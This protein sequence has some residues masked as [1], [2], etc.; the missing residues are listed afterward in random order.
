MTTPPVTTPADTAPPVTAPVVPVATGTT[1]RVAADGS[2]RYRT[3]AEAAAAA[4]PGDTVL[5]APGSYAGLQIPVSGTKDAP[6]T[7]KADGG[8]VTLTSGGTGNG[9]L[10]L[11]GRS[12]VHVVG[13]G[14]S[15]SSRFGVYATNATGIVLQDCEVADSQDGGAVFIDSADIRILGC[16]VHGNN[17]KGTSADMEGVSL[18][19][20]DGFEIA[21]NHVHDNGEEGI[22]TKYETRNG[23]V[24]GN[25]VENNR[26]PNIYVD[27]AHAI[28]VFD[29]VSSGAKESSKAG[30]A[31]AVENY[32]KTRKTY[33]V[34]IYNNVLTGNAGGGISFWT[35]SSGTFSDI[36]IVNNTIVDNKKAGITISAGQFQG[37]NVLRNNIFSGN[38]QD[39][40]GSAA[41]FTADHNL[42]SG[43]SLGA[44]VV[45]GVLRFVNAAAGDLRLAPGSA[46]VDAGSAQGA[47]ATDITGAPRPS[48]AGFDLGA[49][50]LQVVPPAAAPADPPASAGALAPP[51]PSDPAALPAAGGTPTTTAPPVPP[52]APASGAPRTDP[53]AVLAPVLPSAGGAPVG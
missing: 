38:P 26:G 45:T 19:N 3:I 51:A 41:A 43:T 9:R 44:N 49:Y 40:G 15:R 31:L 6:I 46:G 23:T 27:S 42:F 10:D 53:P 48:G 37:T 18:E 35:E 36:S 17:A 39:V 7:F 8:A 1:L 13:I 22:D 33:D 29:N 21:G 2:G 34:Q 24:H 16:D 47:P 4:K 30:I 52:V 11:S 12:Y 32:S 50:E 20:V 28:Q 25:R 5:I 14:V